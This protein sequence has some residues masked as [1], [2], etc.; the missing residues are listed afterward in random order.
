[1]ASTGALRLVDARA[2]WQ[3]CED[4]ALLAECYRGLWRTAAAL[5]RKA[6]A[7]K[8][9]ALQAGREVPEAAELHGGALLA[10]LSQ[11]TGR[12]A[13]SAIAA[14]AERA[15]TQRREF[16]LTPSARAR[17]DA[18]TGMP[19]RRSAIDPLEMAL[20]GAE[21]SEETVN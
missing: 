17:F 8:A 16:G 7:V 15:I 18:D 6:K 11:K 19:N 1:M 13:M 10:L 5:E 4:E 2:L 9:A 12:L 14:L 3:L 20:C 21:S